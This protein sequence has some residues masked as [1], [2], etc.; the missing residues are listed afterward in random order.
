MNHADLWGEK[1]KKEGVGERGG[2]EGERGREREGAGERQRHREREEAGGDEDP[3]PMVPA[4]SLFLA[5]LG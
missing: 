5:H 1:D 2:K 4:S 3:R